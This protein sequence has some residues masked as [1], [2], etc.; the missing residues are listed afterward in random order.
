MRGVAQRIRRRNEI[1]I[2]IVGKRGRRFRGNRPLHA[3]GLPERVIGNRRQMRERIFHR[4]QISIC[5]IVREFRHVI[6]RIRDL[7]HP[8]EH[9]V[10]LKLSRLIVRVDDLLRIP[11]GIVLELGGPAQGIRGTRRLIGGGIDGR[12][13][14]AQRISAADRIAP[15]IKARDGEISPWIDDRCRQHCAAGDAIPRLEILPGIHRGTG[16]KGKVIVVAPPFGGFV[17]VQ[18]APLLV[19][20]LS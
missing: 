11:L 19:A 10:I 16:T 7:G 8:I 17:T 9:G 1:A 12:A 15:G 13:G 14:L 6:Q 3:G 5:R 4:E 18:P 20:P 2:R